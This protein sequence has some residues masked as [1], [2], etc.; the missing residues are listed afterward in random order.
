MVFSRPGRS[1]WLAAILLAAI[2]V[3]V[4]GDDGDS[5]APYKQTQ[6]KSLYAQGMDAVRRGDLSSAY[7]SFHQVVQLLPNSPEAHNSFGWVLL[8]QGQLDP[9]ANEFR[10]S[11]SLR[12]NFAAL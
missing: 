11:L 10:A 2:A 5:T 1:L 8:N 4:S 3:A 7:A 12:P 9:A 6:A